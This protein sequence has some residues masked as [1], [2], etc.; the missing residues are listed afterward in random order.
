M[1]HGNWEQWKGELE[2]IADV[3]LPVPLD[4]LVG[5]SVE[6]ARFVETYWKPDG[7]RP[8]LSGAGRRLTKGVA[9][10]ILSLRAALQEA[11]TNYRLTAVPAASKAGLID[12][13]RF[14]LSEITATIEWV[15]DDDVAESADEQLK[16][17][18]DAHKDDS[19]RAGELA[20]ALHDYATLARGLERRMEGVGG[21]DKKLIDEALRIADELGE[22]R[23]TPAPAP[24][25]T[26]DALRVRNG[27]ASL[28]YDRVSLVRAAARFVFRNHPQ[29]AREV[30]S[31]YQRRRRAE[32]RRRAVK[33]A[34]TGN[35]SP[36]PT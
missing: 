31:P 29:I 22:V 23:A 5:E 14:V 24:Q 3:G 6:V 21:F 4:V 7:D 2:K 12:R 32:A 10:E 17:L 25:S 27:L 1:T 18:Q 33:K 16:S 19:G 11:E 35:P 28:L 8:G 13:A 20:Q 15:L 9:D 36:G 34:P 30:T 26:R